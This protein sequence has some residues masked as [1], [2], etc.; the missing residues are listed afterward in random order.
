VDVTFLRQALASGFCTI[1]AQSPVQRVAAGPDDRVAALHYVDADGNAREVSARAVIIACGAVETPRLLLLSEHA[2]APGGLANESGQV[3]RHFMETVFWNSIGLHPESLGSHRGQPSDSICWDFN[4]P[5]AIPD[6]IGGCRFSPGTAEAG[7]L[8][9]VKYAQRV[10]AGWGRA[11]KEAMRTHF[12]RALGVGAVGESLPNPGSYVD[13]DP[14]AT[15]AAGQPLARIHS[16]LEDSELRRTQFM[17]DT[18]REILRAA[19]VEEIFEEYGSYDTFSSTHVFGT[20]RMGDDPGQS[21][22]DARCRSHRWR[23]LF[24]TDASVFPSSGGG[25]SPSL[26]IEALAIR[27]ADHLAG[28]LSRR[29]L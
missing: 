24:I 26:T 12:G 21:V 3:G 8:G 14:D 27:A 1:Q 17:A 28:L 23:N 2:R 18:A 11:H 29:E 16:H 22:V 10:V 5:D 13:L 15:D 20:C 25:E 4:A 9:P 19:G 6:V 7:L